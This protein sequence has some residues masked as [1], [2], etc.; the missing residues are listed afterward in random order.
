M[1]VRASEGGEAFPSATIRRV[2][3]TLSWGER[4]GDK[5]R[6]AA[7]YGL[8]ISV[9][10]LSR[11][12]QSLKGSYPKFWIGDVHV[13]T[14]L[15]RFV[16]R[17][18]TIDFDIVNPNNEALEVQVFRDI[19]KRRKGKATVCLDVGAHIGKFT[20][21]AAR[22][23]GPQ[24][25]VFAFEPEPSNFSM[26]ERNLRLNKLDNVRPFKTA[27]G[28]ENGEA[29]LFLC[30][31]NTG[32]HSMNARIGEQQIPIQVRKLDDLLEEVGV[33]RVDIL[34]MDVEHAEADVIRGALRTLEKSPDVT[35][36]FEEMQDPQKA[37]SMRLLKD[38]G[39]NITWLAWRVYLASRATVKSS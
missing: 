11:R 23:L 16:C 22:E 5:A 4:F 25:T 24:G 39:F 14:P 28:A 3:R 2:L 20:V 27:C 37:E 15:G 33:D 1:A 12:R 19:L 29:S 34:K 10:V 18:G 38:L 31:Y 36:L 8:Q 6:I 21:F 30:D 17:G 13:N 26:L 35:I 7:F 9:G 32:A